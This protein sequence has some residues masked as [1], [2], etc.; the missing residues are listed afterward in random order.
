MPSNPQKPT[1]LDYRRPQP[2]P[3]RF[4]TGEKIGIGMGASAFVIIALV[5][6]VFIEKMFNC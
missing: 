6:F 1:P 4:S 2:P 3:Y 5:V